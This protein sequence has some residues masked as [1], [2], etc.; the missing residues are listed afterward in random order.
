M[1]LTYAWCLIAQEW[2][3]FVSQEQF[4]HNPSL[5]GSIVAAM[6]ASAQEVQT[7]APHQR[8]CPSGNSCRIKMSAPRGK[9][10]QSLDML[11]AKLEISLFVATGARRGMS[12][13]EFEF[14]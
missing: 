8:R 13:F 4:S 1:L 10:D 9:A 6:A 12:V 14:T 11:G 5:V 7:G 2:Y 3:S